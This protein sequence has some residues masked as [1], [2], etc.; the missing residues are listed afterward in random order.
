MTYVSRKKY[1][2]ETRQ[3]HEQ[4][5][6]IQTPIKSNQTPIKIAKK[7]ARLHPIF[8]QPFALFP[9]ALPTAPGYVDAAEHV[10][11]TRSR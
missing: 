11:R 6:Q 9:F 2:P 7:Q 3:C 5:D 8:V 4:K 10:F 1:T